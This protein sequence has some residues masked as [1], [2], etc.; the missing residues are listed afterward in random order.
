M[1]PPPP[2][3]CNQ[4]GGCNLSNS[5]GV[6]G[7]RKDCH[8]SATAYLRTEEEL[9]LA[10]ANATKNNLKIK[11]VS[12]FSHTIPKLGCPSSSRL[13]SSALV[14]TANYVSDIHIDG[15]NQVVTEDSGVGLRALIDVVEGA[16]L[17]LVAAPY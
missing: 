4:T 9:R 11:F 1:P 14:S 6:W 15:A 7:D 17:R 16:G 2:I 13:G 3:R 8:V 12:K 5:Y 10:V